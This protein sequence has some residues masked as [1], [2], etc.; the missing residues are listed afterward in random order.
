MKEWK[1]SI[2]TILEMKPWITSEEGQDLSDK[3]EE[4]KVWLD[5][6]LEA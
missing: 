1:D 6:K 5:E 4:L 2:A 3:I